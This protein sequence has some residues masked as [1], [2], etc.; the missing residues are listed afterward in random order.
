MVETKMTPH[1]GSGMMFLGRGPLPLY[2]FLVT[3]FITASDQ[4]NVDPTPKL[5]TNKARK[6]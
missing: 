2:P 1:T 4:L 5:K 3:M 6:N